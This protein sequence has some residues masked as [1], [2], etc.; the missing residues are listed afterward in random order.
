[1]LKDLEKQLFPFEK[2]LSQATANPGGGRA[3]RTDAIKNILFNHLPAIHAASKRLAELEAEVDSLKEM[4]KALSAALSESDNA[5][6]KTKSR[7]EPKTQET[8]AA[9]GATE[10]QALRAEKGRCNVVTS[11]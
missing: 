6:K 2:E 7:E 8:F 5:G 9:K 11:V 1:M 3:A 10:A 4:N